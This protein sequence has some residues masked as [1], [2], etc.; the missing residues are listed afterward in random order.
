MPSAPHG[1]R[2]GAAMTRW[3]EIR[4]Y[5]SWLENRPDG[6]TTVSDE[7][8]K[9]YVKVQRLVKLIIRGRPTNDARAMRDGVIAIAE[10][11]GLSVF[12]ALL[13]LRR[14]IQTLGVYQIGTA[15]QNAP[16]PSA[17][18]RSLSRIRKSVDL[19]SDFSS[20]FLSTDRHAIDYLQRAVRRVA[21]EAPRE[22]REALGF[23]IE[24]HRTTAGEFST[25][26]V[27]ELLNRW[28]SL[29]ALIGKA[30]D[31][32]IERQTLRS[33]NEKSLEQENREVPSFVRGEGVTPIVQLIGGTLPDIYETFCRLPF[34][35]TR[36]SVAPQERPVERGASSDA[37]SKL[38]TV[39][40]EGHT[41]RP[42]QP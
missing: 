2:D 25:D 34:T 13:L 20:S 24:V 30:I 7:R 3:Q 21:K 40:S 28:L 32:E 10:E 23:E 22:T 39:L 38:C 41:T 27:P 9:A 19:L 37:P 6:S 14:L 33:Q 18:A 8:L 1:A 29:T 17:I 26:N 4:E 42:L 11:H 15:F 16:Q 5:L 12:Q 31:F 36:Y 35:R